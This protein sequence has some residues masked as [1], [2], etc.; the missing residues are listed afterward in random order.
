[1]F[2]IYLHFLKF[3]YQMKDFVKTVLSGIDKSWKAV[4]EKEFHSAYFLKLME[5]LKDQCN[6]QTIYPAVDKIFAAFN[7]TPFDKI[8]VVIIGQDPYHGKG[9]AHGLCFSVTDGIKSPP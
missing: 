5:F 6:N 8:K 2:Y 1:M 3:K 7:K 9:Q 4:L